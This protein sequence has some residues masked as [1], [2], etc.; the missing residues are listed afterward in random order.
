MGVDDSGGD[1]QEGGDVAFEFE[2]DVCGKTE[3]ES[4]FLRGKGAKGHTEG[5]VEAGR[6]A[7]SDTVPPQRRNRLLPH[8][9]VSSEPSKVLTRKVENLLPRLIE[10]HRLLRVMRV[11]SG[12]GEDDA[13]TRTGGAD[14]DGRME[15]SLLVWREERFGV[16]V[17]DELVDLLWT[18]R[19]QVNFGGNRGRKG[20]LG[21]ESRRTSSSLRLEKGRETRTFSLSFTKFLPDPSPLVLGER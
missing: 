21:I 9:L 5:S 11:L 8:P 16:P 13:G 1:F 14:Y 6:T 18:V 3:S 12:L 7:R 17:V 19:Q 2:V 15:G 20:H 4:R 10:V